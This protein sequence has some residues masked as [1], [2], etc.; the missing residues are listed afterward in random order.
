MTIIIALKIMSIKDI[1]HFIL[2][3]YNLDFKNLSCVFWF[4]V[5]EYL[6]ISYLF[7]DNKVAANYTVLPS[8][9]LYQKINVEIKQELYFTQTENSIYT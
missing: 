3:Y 9:C 4:K 6:L 2:P 8:K 1:Q 7:H 5:V